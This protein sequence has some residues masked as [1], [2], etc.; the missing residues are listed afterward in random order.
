MLWKQPWELAAAIDNAAINPVLKQLLLK[1]FLCLYSSF[2]QLT[3][4][5]IS[6]RLINL[7]Y[8]TLPADIIVTSVVYLLG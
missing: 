1:G 2:S 7:L 8:I 3:S 4:L 5:I 6:E